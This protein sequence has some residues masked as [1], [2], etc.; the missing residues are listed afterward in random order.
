MR[1]HSKLFHVRE[2]PPGIFTKNYLSW[3]DD[4]R[5]LDVWTSGYF[6]TEHPSVET[7][8][9]FLVLLSVRS[10]SLVFIF[11][12]N[13]AEIELKVLLLHIPA[14]FAYITF[15]SL[16]LNWFV[17]KK[18][19]ISHLPREKKGHEIRSISRSLWQCQNMILAYTGDI[20]QNN[21]PMVI[22]ITFLIEPVSKSHNFRPADL[23]AVHGSRP[24]RVL[25]SWEQDIFGSKLVRPDGWDGCPVLTKEALKNN[26]N[27][28]G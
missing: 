21:I 6:V 19:S 27:S 3:G 11:C 18:K 4:D 15:F 7:V 28:P 1:E 22:P 24:C 25:L 9:S 2:I 23:V 17:W 5:S 13:C 12:L 8:K 20:F 26:R 10:P 16:L 14:S